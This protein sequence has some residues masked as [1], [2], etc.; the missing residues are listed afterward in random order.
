[1]FLEQQAAR[2]SHYSNPVLV[3]VFTVPRERPIA[4]TAI[5]LQSNIENY[6]REDDVFDTAFLQGIILFGLEEKD[7]EITTDAHDYLKA[8][9][10]EWI[11]CLVPGSQRFPIPDLAPG[12]Y[13]LVGGHLEEVWRL[14]GDTNG[15][16]LA[17]VQPG[18]TEK[19]FLF[20][21][22]FRGS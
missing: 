8:I 22:Y 21:I 12:P 6:Q 14:R 15:A 7:V 18:Q 20:H 5:W 13:V 10:T 4:I 1:L 9:G 16:F 2:Y 19:V 11:N 3:T 17:A